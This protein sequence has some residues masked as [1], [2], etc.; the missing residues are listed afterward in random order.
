MP[1]WGCRQVWLGLALLPVFLA[2][3]GAAMAAKSAGPL[4]RLF[5]VRDTGHEVTISFR[6]E[7]AFDER[8]SSKLEAGLEIV[9][10]HQVGVRRRRTWWF[11]RN[12]AQKKVVTT[13]IRDTLTG[14]YT[15]NRMVNGGIVETQTT[16]DLEEVRDY[17]TQVNNLKIPLPEGLPRDRRTEIRVRA[18]LET[19]FFL[20]FP[21]S[22][23]TDWVT[24]P[25]ASPVEPPPAPARET[26][27]GER[28]GGP[29][30]GG[31]GAG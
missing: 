15:L 22:Y 14:L 29:S 28:S 17:L 3:P 8:I 23:D 6:V 9:F 24:R 21:Y 1:R 31:G 19:R 27:A 25:L 12:L 10:R 16:S 13:A 26:P 7:N 4:V 2:A 11:E 30:A 20:F 5:E 18:D